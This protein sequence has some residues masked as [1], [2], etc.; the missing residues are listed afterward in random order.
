MDSIHQKCGRATEF[1]DLQIDGEMYIQLRCTAGGV[2]VSI[3][4]KGE[5]RVV[6]PGGYFFLKELTQRGRLSNGHYRY[7]VFTD[8]AQLIQEEEDHANP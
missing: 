7:L 2:A 5:Y 8:F 3:G 1:Q 6:V 4:D